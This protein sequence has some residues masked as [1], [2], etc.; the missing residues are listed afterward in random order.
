M[1]LSNYPDWLPTKAWDKLDG[2]GEDDDFI[3][4]YRL[5][6]FVRLNIQS[7]SKQEAKDILET[8]DVFTLSMD[9]EF[10]Y[11]ETTILPDWFVGY[12]K[13][14]F[15]IEAKNE[16]EA[17]DEL[18]EELLDEEIELNDKVKAIVSEID[19]DQ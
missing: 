18:I 6:V 15:E 16:D 3:E 11:F 17:K 1:R 9:E 4:K 8:Y 13:C 10:L 19:F 12:I 7:P 5:N 14:G 2:K